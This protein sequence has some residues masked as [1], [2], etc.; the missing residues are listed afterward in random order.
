M[1]DKFP[2]SLKKNTIV[3]AAF[4]LRCKLLQPVEV[5]AVGLLNEYKDMNPTLE[6]LPINDVPEQIRRNDPNL[7][8]A[9]LYQISL[10][11]SCIQIGWNGITFV[12]KT[13]YPGWS[14]LQADL[15]SF[16]TYIA[17]SKAVKKLLRVGVRYINFIEADAAEVCKVTF[18]S[19][20]QN[21][22]ERKQFNCSEVFEKDGFLIH[23]IIANKAKL[24]GEKEGSV[25]DI[26]VF[27]NLEQPFDGDVLSRQ[28]ERIHDICREV[29]FSS[30]SEEFLKDLM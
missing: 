8:K 30:I 22:F 28:V 4:D 7:S 10:S 15:N 20:I 18:N 24:N 27:S 3:E 19:G 29:Y 13:C 26:D 23:T 2:V 12:R 17:N 16:I 14:S 6:R 21:T 11:S 5:I 1:N 9:P 25:I